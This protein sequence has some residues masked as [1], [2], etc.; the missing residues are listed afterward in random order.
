[1]EAEGVADV[2]GGEAAPAKPAGTVNDTV[3]LSRTESLRARMTKLSE[4]PAPHLRARFVVLKTL[5]TILTRCIPFLRVKKDACDPP[6]KLLLSVRDLI[7]PEEK[8]RLLQAAIPLTS[9]GK[10]SRVTI[11][12]GRAIAAAEWAEKKG[13]CRDD[14]LRSVFGQLFTDLQK[15]PVS[16]LR[17]EE[18]IW[19]VDL[20]GEGAQDA[21]GPYR[22]TISE[23]CR[24]LMSGATPL[25]ILAPNGRADQGFNRDTRVLNAAAQSSL[26]LQMFKFVG[27]LFGVA[28][29]TNHPLELN[30]APFFWKQVAGESVDVRDLNTIDHPFVK[31]MES[32]RSTAT[33]S[34]WSRLECRWTVVTVDGREV[35]LVPNGAN[36]SVDF[37]KRN[38]YVDMAIDFRL[39]EAKAQA[40]QIRRGIGEMIPSCIVQL[41]TAQEL[42]LAVCGTDEVDAEKLRKHTHH[43]DGENTPFSRMFWEVFES[44]SHEDRRAFLGF[45]WGRTRLP[46]GDSWE[47]EMTLAVMS[48]GSDQSFPHAATCSF[49]I[50]IPAYSTAEIMRQRILY[51]I[52]TTRAID[53]DH[54]VSAGTEMGAQD[55]WDFD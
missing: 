46:Q 11:S 44:F 48:G 13:Y 7:F 29:R 21:G 15:V 4:R 38:E 43:S 32:L 34:E 47:Q 37:D 33:A 6:T 9:G 5:N 25:F 22:E 36:L 20:D 39:N 26:H 53:D 42:S 54:R 27:V 24:D 18:H 12:R 1:V 49:H 45:V 35:A 16:A 3:G 50:D 19:H 31:V 28:L 52:H 14:G 30:L 2:A 10:Q 17:L 41:F 40:E 23:C 8:L 55:D 51:A